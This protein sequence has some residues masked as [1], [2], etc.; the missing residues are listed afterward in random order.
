VLAGLDVMER[1]PE[2]LERLRAN[3]TYA[4]QQLA[5]IGVQ[6]TP[7]AAILAIHAA[8]GMNVRSAARHFH[9]SG[10]FLNAVEYPAVPRDKE[11]F[12]VGLSSVHT[13]EQIDRLVASVAEL[14]SAH[15]GLDGAAS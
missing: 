4:E 6:V 8:P 11:R 15:R 1:E 13:R 12:R 3:V 14:W 2:H 5:A 9:D 7:Q 10:I